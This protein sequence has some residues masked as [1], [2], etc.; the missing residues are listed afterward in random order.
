MRAPYL[1]KSAW[2]LPR[3]DLCNQLAQLQAVKPVSRLARAALIDYSPEQIQAQQ[4][5]L[6]T[7]QNLNDD[8]EFITKQTGAHTHEIFITRRSNFPT[9]N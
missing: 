6:R 2:Q 4:R 8:P 3:V 5:S 7:T 9:E 1:S